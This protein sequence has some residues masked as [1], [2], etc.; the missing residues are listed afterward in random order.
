MA[1]AATDSVVFNGITYRRYPGS[2][3]LHLRSYFW[4]SGNYRKRGLSSLHRDIWQ[5]F[6]GPIPAG[7]DIHHRDENSLNNDPSNLECKPKFD[8]ISGH[9]SKHVERARAMANQYRPL[10][11]AWHSSPEGIR[12]HTEHGKEN[13]KAKPLVAA[14]CIECG[15]GYRTK[16]PDQSKF[17]SNACKSRARRK[18]GL[19]N[20][21]KPC[22]FCQ[23]PFLSN[24]FDAIRYCSRSCAKRATVGNRVRLQSGCFAQS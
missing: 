15:E 22:E 24:R 3:H 12:W 6:N 19:D 16:W 18:S 1:S 4:C 13:F 2:K 20:I 5:H 10:T 8:H 14:T 23:K 9:A 11:K 21:E 17:C 7:C